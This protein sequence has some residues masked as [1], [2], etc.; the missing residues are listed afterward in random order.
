MSPHNFWH[1]PGRAMA[2]ALKPAFTPAIVLAAALLGSCGG[3]GDHNGLPYLPGVTCSTPEERVW[4]SDYFDD[5][6]FWNRLA[7]RPSPLADRSLAEFFQ[8]SLYTGT[9]LRF[10]RDRW[11]RMEPSA[12][13]D[14]FFSDGKA[15]G[16]GLFPAGLEIDG[17]P[18][19]ALRVRDVEPRS[20][21]AAQGVQ[22]GDEVVSVNGRPAS[23]L[24]AS[25]DYGDFTPTQA[26]Q[27]LDLVLRGPSGERAVRLKAGAYVLTPVRHGAVVQTTAGR[28]MGY[29]MVRD[30]ISQ[31]TDPMAAV[32][33]DFKAAGVQELVIDLRYN[34]CGLVSVA[35]RLASFVARERTHD[36][37]FVRLRYNERHD[38]SS[39]E[40]IRFEQPAQA[41]NL[42]R[43]YV[44]T[45]P[46]TCSA[47]ELVVN[48]LRPFVDVV[49]I[50]DTTCGKPVGY[51]P[52]DRCD[53]TFSV[54]NFESVNARDEGRYFNGLAANCAVA[55]DV[56]QALGSPT[57]PLL[58]AARQHAD[59]GQC[60][61]TAA[62]TAGADRRP[63]VAPHQSGSEPAERQ[64]MWRR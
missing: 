22:R 46:R 56:G 34:G 43:V 44:L 14:R 54:V 17:N 52:V 28:P 36:R 1:R 40:D 26:G 60:L 27:A 42:S 18:A 53:T 32:F 4:L 62:A 33:A 12:D 55:E 39:N 30:M 7:P 2:S 11:S 57:E 29:L 20:D 23:Q 9:D 19:R 61:S 6:Y 45:G 21:A 31:A 63:L 58:A 49:T 35:N 37:D 10:P 41:L 51:R 24:V 13:F 3:G 59:S 15:L 25:S 5:W 16:Y 47:S 64:G 8:A 38:R 48:G 50:G